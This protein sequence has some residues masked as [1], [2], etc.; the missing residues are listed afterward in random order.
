MTKVAQQDLKGNDLQKNK[1]NVWQE[2]PRT[3]NQVGE[4]VRIEG[5]GLAPHMP[6]STSPTFFNSF[7]Q[8]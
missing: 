4:R 8:T 5:E 3:P 7:E 6:F 2:E 1:I